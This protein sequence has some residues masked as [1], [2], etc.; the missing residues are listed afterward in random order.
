MTAGAAR[1][2]WAA[3]LLDIE[4]T[5]TPITFV[6]RILFPYARARLGTFASTHGRDPVVVEAVARLRD[7]HAADVKAGGAPPPWPVAGFVG[8]V[9]DTSNG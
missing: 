5:T 3:V 8:L 9:A 4:G 6:H 7:E 1:S 2:D